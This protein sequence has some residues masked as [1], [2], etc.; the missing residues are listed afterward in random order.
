MV[1][2]SDGS[3]FF[4]ANIYDTLGWEVR[5]KLVKTDANFQIQ[6][7]QTF[8]GDSSLNSTAYYF[9]TVGILP[10]GTYYAIGD[11]YEYPTSTSAK[12][13]INLSLSGS[14]LWIKM[15]SDPQLGYVHLNPTIGIEPGSGFL[16]SGNTQNS[17][18]NPSYLALKFDFSGNLLWARNCTSG[19]QKNPSYA[20]T[21]TN[22]G[23]MIISGK[24]SSDIFL[25]RLNTNGNVIWT[26]RYNDGSYSRAYA[27]TALADGSFLVGGYVAGTS[28]AP[29][30]MKIDAVGNVIWRK[31]YGFNNQGY[32]YFSS[33]TVLNNGQILFSVSSGVIS[34]MVL[35]RMDQSGNVLAAHN[36]ESGDPYFTFYFYNNANIRNTPNDC[37]YMLAYSYD[38]MAAGYGSIFMQ[39]DWLSFSWCGKSD[40]SWTENSAAWTPVITSNVYYSENAGL[41]VSDVNLPVITFNWNLVNINHCQ[42]TS[43]QEYSTSQINISPNPA[44]TSITITG[45][46]GEGNVEIFN[47]LGQLT[48][49]HDLTTGNDINIQSLSPGIYFLNLKDNAGSIR[50]QKLIIEQ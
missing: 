35:G 36:I 8:F 46:E 22:D 47:S 15:I 42:S 16:I 11:Y 34:S 18:G 20:S 30:A 39:S 38:A 7:E 40:I 44:T 5:T 9:S 45:V 2:C 26:K 1:K 48:L 6:W 49:T 41:M 50:T 25:A 12:V 13:L 43:T 14:I 37:P 21:V 19:D 3:Y 23:G 4:S 29:F 32:D 17:A 27:I 24:S 33:F 28:A 31:S 10:N